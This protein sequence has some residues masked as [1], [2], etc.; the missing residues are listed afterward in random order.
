MF[1]YGSQ[2]NILVNRHFE[3]AQLRAGVDQSLLSRGQLFLLTGEPGIGKTRLADELALYADLRGMRVLWGRCEEGG[4][5]P[6]F[7]PW[8][9]ILREC[10]QQGLATESARQI[11]AQIENF[12]HRVPE[13]PNS[14]LLSTTPIGGAAREHPAH[15][16]MFDWMANCLRIAARSRPLLLVIDDLHWSDEPSSSLLRFT[17]RALRDAAVMI[18]VTCR[19]VE[20]Q[21]RERMAWI[22]RH[23]AGECSHLP[24]RSLDERGVCEMITGMSGRSP[25][26]T[27]ANAVHRATGGNPLFVRELSAGLSANP[28][29]P[30][31]LTGPGAL[32]DRGKMSA[33]VR[34]TIRARLTSISRETAQILRL[35]AVFGGEFDLLILEDVSEEGSGD[36]LEALGE[37]ESAGIVREVAG[38]PGRYRFVHGLVRDQLYDDFPLAARIRLHQRIAEALERLSLTS[39]ESHLPEIAY[40]YFESRRLGRTRQAFHYAQRA[41]DRA[42]AAS[43]F[44]D[45]IRLYRMAIAVWDLLPPSASEYSQRC[46]LLLSLADAQHKVA[47]EEASRASLREAAAISERNGDPHRFARAALGFPAAYW[48]SPKSFEAGLVPLLRRAL[49]MLGG[50]SNGLRAMLLARLAAELPEHGAVRHERASLMAEAVTIARQSDDRE[51]L[52]YILSYRD[53]LLSGTRLIDERLQNAAEILSISHATENYACISRSALSRAVSFLRRGDVERANIEAQ[54]LEFVAKQVHQPSLDWRAYCFIAARSIME[55]SFDKGEDL[56]RR[57]VALGEQ[58]ENR[59]M[60]RHFWYAMLMPFGERGRL[61]ELEEA[62]L[63]AVDERPEEI[64]FKALLSYFYCELGQLT[65]ARLYLE[66]LLAKDLSEFAGEDDFVGA[67]AA[68]A[69]VCVTLRDTA[70]ASRLYDLLLPHSGSNVVVGPAAVFGSV[71]RYLGLLSATLGRVDQAM[72]HFEFALRFNQKIGAQPWAAYVRYDWA[73]MLI[74]RDRPAIREQALELVRSAAESA[75]ALGLNRLHG[76]AQAL[77]LMAENLIAGAELE[78]CSS[79]ESLSSTPAISSNP[80]EKV[81]PRPCSSPTSVSRVFRREGEYWT[82][83]YEGVTVRLRHSKGLTLIGHLLRHPFQDF[84]VADLVESCGGGNDCRLAVDDLSSWDS[85]E[86]DPVLDPAAKSAYKRRLEE[87]RDELE[88]AKS[89]NDPEGADKRQE[90]IEYLTDE[91][92]RAIGLGGRDRYMYS[93]AERARVRITNAIKAAEKKIIDQNAKLGRY[94]ARTIRTGAFCSYMPDSDGESAWDF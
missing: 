52:L 88:T 11:E 3:M 74:E 53:W 21:F 39:S 70:H 1:Q 17:A 49:S 82:I 50:G 94:F 4:D 18:L 32:I 29:S 16:R 48:P 93:A 76:K 71:S 9:Q 14:Q 43:M 38:S 35:A 85:G 67:L 44:D 69:H 12:G 37:A 58:F 66:E 51:A 55:G 25:S 73:R 31:F 86:P 46:D 75:E 84:H 91:L 36:L 78:I 22:F 81:A 89:L 62:A 7:W 56:A 57:C 61:H 68:L 10:V 90:E 8:I 28:S 30:A 79:G 42:L 15:F 34:S 92:S 26:A 23:L 83:S 40:H 47:A 54:S 13:L 5:T 72:G 65:K 77:K 20:L 60:G 27:V 2:S 87:L 6:S 59:E 24:I 33:T 45:A 63:R 41:A 64:A 80:S 19:D